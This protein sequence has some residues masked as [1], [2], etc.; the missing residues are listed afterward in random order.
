MVKKYIESHWLVFVIQ[1]VVALLFGWFV[2]FTGISDV[3]ALIPIVAISILCLGI[4][5]TVNL[6]HREHYQQGRGLT[7]LIALMDIAASLSLFATMG[8]SV[9]W[10]LVIIAGY[11]LIRGLLE[12]FLAFISI[13][14]ATD[15]FIW[16]VCGICGV[17]LGFVILN[18]G[19]FTETT[20]FIK[21][22]GSYMMIFGVSSLTYGAHN[23]NRQL[24][25]FEEHRAAIAAR[26]AARRSALRSKI[27]RKSSAKTAS[28]KSTSTKSTSAAPAKITHPSSTPA[29]SSKTAKAKKK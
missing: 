7:V 1:G 12:I 17:I 16:L 28:A 27:S 13:T 3:Q 24:E 14:D 10:Q 25:A 2:M 9:A 4:I 18:S 11:T 19:H 20:T 15:R 29:K 8:Q 5:Q 26:R 23:H 6:L 21:F 22:F